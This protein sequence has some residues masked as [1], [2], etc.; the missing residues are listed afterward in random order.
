MEKVNPIFQV[1]VASSPTLLAAGSRPEAL[2]VGQLGIFNADTG[3]SV[4]A[5]LP[6]R[7]YFAVGIGDEAGNLVDVRMSSQQEI[8]KHLVSK[9]TSAKAVTGSNQEFEL[10]LTNFVPKYDTNYTIRM[11]FRAGETMNLNG[12]NIPTKSFTV[13]TPCDGDC[14]G[15]YDLAD[16][17]DLVVAEITRNGEGIVT[18]E[19]DGTSVNITVGST[20]KSPSINGTVARYS[21]LRQIVATLSLSNGFEEGGYV[22]NETPAV[23]AKGDGYDLLYSEGVSLGW[24]SGVYRESTLNGFLGKEAVILTD[25]KKK[26]WVME[27]LHNFP[28]NSGGMLNYLNTAQT[29][30]A[31]ESIAGN[32]AFT[33]A[34]NGLF[35]TLVGAQGQTTGTFETIS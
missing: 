27:I 13:Y 5:A 31:I 19:T 15:D 32:N 30:I 21:L 11:T 24:L 7:F 25:P 22:V 14:T 33:T 1:L 2:A 26:Y 23:Y 10:D 18:A 9:I 3:L 8:K 34:L 12:F 35:N 6:D 4:T 28:S 29:I 16:F 17:C 20:A